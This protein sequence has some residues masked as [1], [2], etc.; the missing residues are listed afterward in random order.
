MSEGFITQNA[1]SDAPSQFSTYSITGSNNIQPHKK[2]RR[3]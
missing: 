3:V 1:E 2:G